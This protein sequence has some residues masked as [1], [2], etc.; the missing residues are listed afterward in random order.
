MV[1]E[2]GRI[3]LIDFGIARTFKPQQQADTVALG[4]FGFAAPEQL[5][6]EQTGPRSDLFSLGAVLYYLLSGGT[7][8]GASPRPLGELR[9][10]VT[11]TLLQLVERLLAPLP[12]DRPGQAEEVLKAIRQLENKAGS[13][14]SRSGESSDISASPREKP[15]LIV[16][17]G[18]Y[19]GAGA[20]FAAFSLS[21]ALRLARLEHAIGEHPAAEPEHYALLDGERRAPQG[22]RFLSEQVL[23]GEGAQDSE[24]SEDGTLFVPSPPHTSGLEGWSTATA[25]EWLRRIERPIV[26]V[27][28]SHLWA[29]PRVQPLLAQAD[30]LLVV[31][32]PSPAKLQRPRVRILL[33][34]LA[35]MAQSGSRLT[36]V[37]NRDMAAKHRG[38]WLRMLPAQ[39]MISLPDFTA[40]RLLDAQWK[41]VVVPIN[42][43]EREQAGRAFAMFVASRLGS[44]SESV[45]R[46]FKAR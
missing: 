24:W 6:G 45:R 13:A 40:A 18:L 26:I 8:A 2:R 23:A 34:E 10:D 41:G 42:A 4:T 19:P 15:K 11:E 30:E 38:D 25:G 37:A 20:T 3:K 32:D 12:E 28:I 39:D 21:Y 14:E 35:A 36:W 27:D 7:Y 29:D 43:A 31:A 1:D 22:Y 46:K 44:E 33:R 17:G 5:R 16:V 9:P